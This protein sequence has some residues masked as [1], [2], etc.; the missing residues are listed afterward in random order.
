[1]NSFWDWASWDWNAAN[2]GF[3]TKG[4]GVVINAWFVLVLVSFAVVTKITWN[5]LLVWWWTV[6]MLDVL[7]FFKMLTV[8][9]LTHGNILFNVVFVIWIFINVYTWIAIH[10]KNMIFIFLIAI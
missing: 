6:A 1:M 4:R 5:T 10:V 7:F 3:T 2:Y 9:M 8:S